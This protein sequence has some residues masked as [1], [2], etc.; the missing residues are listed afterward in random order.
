[1]EF[2]RTLEISTENITSQDIIEKNLPKVLLFLTRLAIFQ[3]K[4][5]RRTK[6]KRNTGLKRVNSKKGGELVS[7]VDQV[8]I[9][10]PQNT[11]DQITVLS[12]KKQLRQTVS[13]SGTNVPLEVLLSNGSSGG[14]PSIQITSNNLKSS[15]KDNSVPPVKLPPR[16]TDEEGLEP[17]KKVPT[18]PS[19]RDRK[20]PPIPPPRNTNE[21]GLEPEKKVPPIPSPRDRKL[22]PVP[23]TEKPQKDEVKDKVPP[24]VPPKTSKPVNP[25]PPTKNQIKKKAKPINLDGITLIEE[26]DMNSVTDDLK[27]LNNVNL[28]SLIAEMDDFEN[29]FVE[30]NTS[31]QIDIT[32][33][34]LSNILKENDLSDLNVM[35]VDIDKLKI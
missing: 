22:P 31:S 6:S 4:G 28:S 27:S 13:P 35:E 5:G 2:C 21:E 34:N 1:L 20:L 30:D 7:D 10:L 29:Q 24:K 15:N 12:Q 33:N 19:P 32:F 14:E 26:L 18:I 11:L 23:Q 16:K 25:E 8:E 17:E 9:A 3:S